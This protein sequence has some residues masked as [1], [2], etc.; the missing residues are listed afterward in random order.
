VS[1]RVDYGCIAEMQ[2]ELVAGEI[3]R[4]R[5]DRIARHPAGSFFPL[6]VTVIVTPPG[7]VVTSGWAAR[8]YS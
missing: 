5:A 7:S 1:T 4:D 6:S 8:V 2:G 3:D